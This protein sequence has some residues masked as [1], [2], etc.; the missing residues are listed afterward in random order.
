MLG[1]VSL[2]GHLGFTYILRPTDADERINLYP[3]PYPQGG[4][5]LANFFRVPVQR[6]V[7]TRAHCHFGSSRHHPLTPGG[8][9]GTELSPIWRQ[10]YMSTGFDPHDYAPRVPADSPQQEMVSE[11]HGV[12]AEFSNNCL[13][14][15]Q[16]LFE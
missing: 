5:A 8:V 13:S 16:D 14:N 1:P 6:V 11:A 15:P 10:V 7:S 3:H 12:A 4:A 9:T 2:L